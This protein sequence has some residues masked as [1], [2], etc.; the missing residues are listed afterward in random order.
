VER[1]AAARALTT[2]R[3]AVRASAPATGYS[4]ALAGRDDDSGIRRLLRDA[5]FPGDVRIA[6]EREP[7]ALSAGA[8]EGGVHQTIV[9]RQ[10]TI[11]DITAI[12]TRSVRQRFVNGEEHPV[13]YLSQLRIAPGYRRH[14][15][16]LDAGFDYCR[17]LHQD[18]AARVYLASVI[19]DNAA[20]LKLLSRQ[21]PGWPRFRPVATLTTL[22]IPVRHGRLP[23]AAPAPRA[24]H[25]NED[26][27]RAIGCLLRNGPRFQFSPVWAAD[28][29]DGST[30][31]L[32]RAA[33][34]I[35]E[36]NGHVVGCAALWDQ[37]AFRQVVVRGYSRRLAMSR[38]WVNAT[39]RWTGMPALPPIGSRLEFGYV[40]HLAVD[41][42]DPDVACALIAAVC[43][44]ARLKGLDYVAVGLPADAP[45]TA[46]VRGRFRHR[47]Y[48]SVLHVA[49]WPDGEDIVNRL[50]GRPYLPELGTL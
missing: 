19:A 16:L 47:A 44:S 42:D 18:D 10:G 7:D 34:R 4:F 5:E 1:L 22:A 31:G 48:Q 41:D 39:A 2:P 17:R 3:I 8:Q 20:A 9:A 11:P 26:V 15:R 43:E 6:F 29:F 49:F 30:P 50:D 28:A 14:R 13:G 45:M 46:A 35:A 40:S 36:R 32:S 12:A 27:Q 21:A 37:R 33:V 23:A 24:T 25:S 38:W